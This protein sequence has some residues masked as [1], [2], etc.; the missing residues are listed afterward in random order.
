MKEETYTFRARDT[1]TGVIT[2]TEINADQAEKVVTGQA[3]AFHPRDERI[4]VGE[5]GE[6][7]RRESAIPVPR[8][9]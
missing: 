8:S 4:A 3:I 1:E 6:I 5:N 2:E 9:E 7:V